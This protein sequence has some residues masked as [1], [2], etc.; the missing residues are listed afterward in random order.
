MLKFVI[1]YEHISSTV[2]ENY[3]LINRSI[4]DAMFRMRIK[5]Y[6]EPICKKISR[7]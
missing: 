4:E 1:I 5:K 7:L 3:W 6:G 2:V